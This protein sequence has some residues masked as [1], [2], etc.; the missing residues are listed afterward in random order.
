MI[1]SAYRM[2]A[3][4]QYADLLRLSAKRGGSCRQTRQQFSPHRQHIFYVATAV[5]GKF[6]SEFSPLAIIAHVVLRVKL[7]IPTAPGIERYDTNLPSVAGRNHPLS[8]IWHRLLWP[9]PGSGWNR[10]LAGLLSA[11]TWL[12]GYLS[13]KSFIP[14]LAFLPWVILLLSSQ[15]RTT[16][17]AKLSQPCS[18]NKEQ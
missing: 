15:P 5:N 7:I 14:L 2:D 16:L 6:P 13:L 10:L 3:Q 17:P 12:Y 1:S 9:Q 18:T 11:R 8:C 4:D